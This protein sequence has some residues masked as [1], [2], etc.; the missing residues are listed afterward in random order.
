MKNIYILTCSALLLMGC[1]TTSSMKNS[2]TFVVGPSQHGLS[3]VFKNNWPLCGNFYDHNGNMPV[4]R[5]AKYLTHDNTCKI[6]PEAYVPE[7]IIIEY[8][9][10][11]T[12]EEQ[13]KI[14]S[15]KAKSVYVIRDEIQNGQLVKDVVRGTDKEAIKYNTTTLAKNIELAIDKIPNSAWKQIVLYPPQEVAKYKNQLSEGKG[16]SK[17]GKEIHYTISLNPDGTYTITTK[18]YWKVPY[19]KNWN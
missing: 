15:L 4:K 13:Q 10:W 18:L 17:R 14:P 6:E 8:A 5:Q 12:Y 11:L 2:I 16:D 1:Q 9:P 19:Q 7:K 3:F